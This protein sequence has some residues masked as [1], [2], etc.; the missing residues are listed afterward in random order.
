MT[1]RFN[2]TL[3]CSLI[4][5]IDE[6]QKNWDDK[7][8]SV[9]FGYRVAK[10]RTTGYSPF[11]MLY[12]REPSL[13][14]DVE[15]MSDSVA[16]SEEHSVDAYIATMVDVRDSLKLDAKK[17][18]ERS[19]KYQKSH[20]DKRQGSQVNTILTTLSSPIF[21]CE[22]LAHPHPASHSV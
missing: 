21:Q 10:Q 18:I 22:K 14:I 17:N 11:F 2:Q 8:D 6:D 16:D 3:S 1:E 5:I 12:H 15:V 7:L 9:L 13:P 19:Q 20:Y 4:K